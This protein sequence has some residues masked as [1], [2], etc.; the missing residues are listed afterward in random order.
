MGAGVVVINAEQF[1]E[2]AKKAGK[3]YFILSQLTTLA[4]WIRALTLD[5]A[6]PLAKYPSYL[7]VF[8]TKAARVLPKHHPMEH[9]IETELG[10]ELP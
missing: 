7:D 10:K 4:L 1:Y 3:I 6:A 2:E 9:K 5:P 8:D